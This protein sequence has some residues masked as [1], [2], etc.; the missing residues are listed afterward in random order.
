MSSARAERLRKVFDYLVFSGVF[1]TRA[2][3]AD[4][5][6]TNKTN[7]SS[8]MNGNEKY[9]SDSLF[10]KI[11]SVYDNISLQWLMTGE[12]EMLKVP[13][14][15]TV[16]SPTAEEHKEM[17]E[18]VD[19]SVIPAEVVEEIKEEVR[20]EI[21][22]EIEPK[23]APLEIARKPNL[24]TMEWIK[25]GSGR[26]IS[27]TFNMMAILQDTHFYTEVRSNAM[28][29]ALTQGEVL[30]LQPFEDGYLFI[31][32]HPY[33]V[34]TKSRGLIVFYLYDRGDHVECRPHN[35]EFGTLTIPK[36]DII[37]YYKILFHGSTWI[38]T[39]LPRGGCQQQVAKQS[40]QISTLIGEVC[41]AGDRVDKMGEQVSRVL[42][43]MERKL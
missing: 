16:Y 3:F 21:V 38:E 27:S 37:R 1:T 31:D 39:S 22:E 15:L 41:K 7:L 9:L 24:D 13:A 8:A 35:V 4:A 14:T 36:D 11:H 2:D 17:S 30:F 42:D 5:I 19:L 20:A 12:G 23:F 33:A 6:G 34:E 40:E 43:M 18:G 25:K 10:A 28:S 32:G 26:N 29:P